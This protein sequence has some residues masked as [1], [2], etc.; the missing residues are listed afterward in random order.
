MKRVAVPAGYLG[1]TGF[2]A[3]CAS[4]S[5]SDCT[6]T[7]FIAWLVQ[8]PACR[9][10]AVAGTLIHCPVAVTTQHCTSAC[11]EVG[12]ADMQGVFWGG[13]T[14]LRSSGGDRTR[15]NG[16][17]R[18]RKQM[19][20]FRAFLLP[21][22]S[23]VGYEC[24]SHQTQLRWRLSLHSH[25]NTDLAGLRRPACVFASAADI[26]NRRSLVHPLSLIWSSVCQHASSYGTVR[27]V[28]L[29]VLAAVGSSAA[30][31]Q[32]SFAFQVHP[33]LNPNSEQHMKTEVASGLLN[34]T[35]ASINAHTYFS[36]EESVFSKGVQYVIHCARTSIFRLR[37]ASCSQA[38]MRVCSCIP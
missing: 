34:C 6:P 31:S 27:V 7:C 17:V 1:R 32:G 26:F 35:K 30:R 9:E 2:C 28:A 20:A 38:Y 12:W 4:D 29:L 23:H 19:T 16:A 5:G 14:A 3:D 10:A 15:L 18:H 22:G 13:R 8:L 33:E 25:T 37:A 24:R 21:A 36:S 11:C